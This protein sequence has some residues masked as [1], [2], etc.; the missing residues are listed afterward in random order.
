M[1]IWNKLIF[2]VI[3][4]EYDGVVRQNLVII[5]CDVWV[6]FLDMREEIQ[7]LFLFKLLYFCFCVFWFINWKD[8][9]IFIQYENYRVCMLIDSFFRYEK[10]F[11]S[12][13]VLE[14]LGV[15]YSF[16]YLYGVGNLG[17]LR[18]FVSKV[19]YK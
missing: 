15:F 4:S 14:Q 13:L 7:I 3:S 8:L 9:Y 10:M 11:N 2:R 19:C 6:I 1:R 17:D 12:C 5:K 16:G 18:R